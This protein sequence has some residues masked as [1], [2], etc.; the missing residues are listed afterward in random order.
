MLGV[1]LRLAF[2]SGFVYL[3]TVC[4]IFNN[5]FN[6]FV[7][8]A[9]GT[10]LRYR[11]YRCTDCDLVWKSPESAD[12]S[13]KSSWYA[14]C[15][16]SIF[17]AAKDAF[18]CSKSKQLFETLKSLHLENSVPVPGVPTTL[19][20]VG[21][22]EHGVVSKWSMCSPDIMVFHEECRDVLLQVSLIAATATF[23]LSKPTVI[24]VFVVFLIYLLYINCNVFVF[25]SL[26][27][28]FFH[29]Q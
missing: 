27:F 24:V 10:S 8:L 21:P 1:T 29:V 23:D 22:C 28:E 6:F 3:F 12:Y 9:S 16:E 5:I 19:L 11:S 2:G 17:N 4:L 20:P 15:Y 25:S 13:R 18:Q 14:V 26:V 7:L